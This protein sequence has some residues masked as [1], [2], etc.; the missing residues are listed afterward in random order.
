MRHHISDTIFTA[1]SLL[2][3]SSQNSAAYLILMGHPVY[4]YRFFKRLFLFVIHIQAV[5]KQMR[6]F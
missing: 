5:S 1:T 2:P 4:F 3:F 6:Q